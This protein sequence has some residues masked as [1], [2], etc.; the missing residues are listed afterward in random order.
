MSAGFLDDITSNPLSGASPGSNN[1]RAFYGLSPVF[2]VK[3]PPSITDVSVTSRPGDGTDTFKRGERIEVTFTFDEPVTVDTGGA[4]SNVRIR[5][6]LRNGN[7]QTT[8]DAPFLRQDHPSKLVFAL[9]VVASH[10]STGTFCVGGFCGSDSILLNT[11]TASPSIVAASDGA[12]ANRNYDAEFTTWKIDGSTTGLTGGV[13][14]RHP[15]VRDAIVA[16]QPGAGNCAG[17]T[18]LRLTAILELNVSQKSIVSL[19]KEDFAGLTKL[20]T[21]NL[22]GNDLDRLADD[23]FER[24]TSLRTL[25]LAE[26]DLTAFPA[27]ALDDVGGTLEDLFLRD[28]AIA[29]IGAG[30][31]DGLTALRRLELRGNDLTALPAGVFDRTTQ[32]RELRLANNALASLPDDLLAPLTLLETVWLTGNPGFDGFA[33]VVED[34]PARTAP[35]GQRVDLAAATGASPWGDNVTWSWARTDT[36]GGDGNAAGRGHGDALFHGAVAERRHGTD[37][38]GDRDGP[39]H[40]RVGRQRGQRDGAGHGARAAEDCRHRRHLAPGRRQHHLQARRPHRGHRHVQ[41]APCGRA[42]AAT[43]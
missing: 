33:P 6:G 22:S 8:A 7:V 29:T 17:V 21:L 19:R 23:L 18:D 10:S 26:N 36:N 42:G 40:H 13:C 12:N 16:A 25:N 11:A 1:D 14:D 41:R 28:N 43:W 34:I 20:R 31:L 38:R 4:N 24:L 32:L 2:T 39:R 37:L 15:A 35:R 27:G 5:L 9:T 30:A 3:A